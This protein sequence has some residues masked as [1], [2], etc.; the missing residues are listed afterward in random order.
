MAF[1]MMASTLPVPNLA[2]IDVRSIGSE[3]VVNI[4]VD[5]NHS[6]KAAGRQ[7]RSERPKDIITA[8]EEVASKYSPTA[9]HS[10]SSLQQRL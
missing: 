4:Q 5:K 2:V 9:H 6:F 10:Q 8:Q 1:I 7:Q 3:Q